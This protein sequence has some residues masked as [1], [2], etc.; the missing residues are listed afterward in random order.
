M[1]KPRPTASIARHQSG[2]DAAAGEHYF[3]VMK[4]QPF[5]SVE[6][7]GTSWACG[8]GRTQRAGPV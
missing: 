4:E 1:V 5:V 7:T 2:R 6:R 3:R 8:S